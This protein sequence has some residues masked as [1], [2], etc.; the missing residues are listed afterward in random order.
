MAEYTKADREQLGKQLAAVCRR[1]LGSGDVS[2]LTQLSGGASI[3]SW[4]FSFASRDWILRR[5][6]GL[7]ANLTV[8]DGVAMLS[9]SD[10][11][12]LL[13]HVYSQGVSVPEV[14]TILQP[15]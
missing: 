4:R 15:Q 13:Q 12:S 2:G 10:Q 8:P 11:A 14:L 1:C 9:L 6:P 5:L 3:E 7:S